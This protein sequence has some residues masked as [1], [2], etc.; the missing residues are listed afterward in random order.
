MGQALRGLMYLHSQQIIHKD[1]KPHNLLVMEESPICVVVSDFDISSDR[2]RNDRTTTGHG[3]PQG[4]PDYMAPEVKTGNAPD[5]SS[6][7]YSFG[8]TMMELTLGRLPTEDDMTAIRNSRWLTS[9]EPSESLT[10][11]LNGLLKISPQHRW[12][13]EQ[14]QSEYFQ[15]AQSPVPMYWKWDRDRE[16]FDVTERFKGHV[17]RILD[18]TSTDRLGRGND[19]RQS[20]SYTRLQVMRV[21]QIENEELWGRY[22]AERKEMIRNQN[23][24]LEKGHTTDAV[25]VK[26]ATELNAKELDTRT[27]EVYLLHGMRDGVQEKI[28][29][30]GFEERLAGTGAGTIYGLG[31]YFAENACKADQYCTPNKEQEFHMFLAR[32]TLGGHCYAC[33]DTKTSIAGHFGG[34][35]VEQW[36][37]L[38]EVQGT[39]VTYS[40]LVGTALARRE[41]VVFRGIQAYPEYLITYKRV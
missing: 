15:R 5:Q 26:T 13:A 23:T 2:S 22:V 12:T 1:I 33:N 14:A 41:F 28:A 16:W 21:Q 8:V 25:D 39:G 11:L 10:T 24:L 30:K 37:M 31:S 38:P 35:R 18:S 36:K 19:Q 6:D 29:L 7:L 40:S 20:Q 3:G 27:N 4:T 32:V 17:Q 34:Q 9:P